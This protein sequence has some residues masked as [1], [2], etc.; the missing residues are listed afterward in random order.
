MRLSEG[1]SVF[2]VKTDVPDDQF[3]IKN[4]YETEIADF[5]TFHF[6]L[7][8]LG[9]KQS[10]YHEKRRS[11]YTYK[12]SE[13]VID[14]YPAIPPYLEIEGSREEIHE[15]VKKLGFTMA[16]T[17]PMNVHEVFELY[18]IDSTNLRF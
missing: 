2:T 5:E 17:S 18:G 16:Q 7:D 12:N 13:I 1:K 3:K 9:F 14:K 15:I 10:R 6:Q 4:E 11:T 8:A